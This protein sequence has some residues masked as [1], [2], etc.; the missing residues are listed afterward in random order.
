MGDIM[1]LSNNA[2]KIIAHHTESPPTTKNRRRPMT[3]HKRQHQLHRF[4]TGQCSWDIFLYHWN[5]WLDPTDHGSLKCKTFGPTK[6]VTQ[7]ISLGK[8]DYRKHKRRNE[9]RICA[10]VGN[11]TEPSPKKTHTA[12][13][14][15]ITARHREKK[16]NKKTTWK[17]SHRMIQRHTTTKKPKKRRLFFFINGKQNP[18]ISATKWWYTYQYAVKP[19]P[20]GVPKLWRT[21]KTSSHSQL[22]YKQM[23]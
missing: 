2:V 6:N 11:C 15:I 5:I 13:T 19:L 1:L 8:S 23:Q 9:V 3:D 22:K 4:R 16:Q 10:F 12:I 20:F 17:N 7:G 18:I 14:P 21:K